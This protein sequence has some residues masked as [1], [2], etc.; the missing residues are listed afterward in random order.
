MLDVDDWDEVMR[1][2]SDQEQRL[3]R[4]LDTYMSADEREDR[5]VM[6]AWRDMMEERFAPVDVLPANAPLGALFRLR[7]D[8]T[9]AL[10]LGNGPTRPLTKLVPVPV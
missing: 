5:R 9:G 7:G 3:Q 10:Y 2:L 6:R 4:R 8:T 1:M